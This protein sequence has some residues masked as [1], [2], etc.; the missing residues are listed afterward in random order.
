MQKNWIKVITFGDTETEKHHH[1]KNLI[2]LE[3][4]DIEK[5]QESSIVSS[6]KRIYKY[7]IGYKDHDHKIKPLH[8]MLPK[9]S[10]YMKSFEGETN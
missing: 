2:L 5:I 9:T 8:I 10:A 6:G 7:F 4:V 3:D 1:R